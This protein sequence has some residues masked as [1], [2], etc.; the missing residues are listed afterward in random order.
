MTFKNINH[1]S[2]SV[3]LLSIT[4]TLNNY[5]NA[6]GENTM[7][8]STIR[9]P[10]EFEQQEA[11]WLQWPGRWE[12]DSEAAFAK[13]TNIIVQYEKLHILHNNNT[14]R[15]EARSAIK[16]AGGNPDHANITWH[17]IGNDSAWMRDNGPVYVVQDGEMRIQNWQFDAWGGAFGKNILTVLIML[18][19]PLLVST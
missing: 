13:M 12:K 3:F 18:C 10:A 15:K 1:L 17:E 6:T 8:T 19:Q 2:I 5:A 11:I 14:I 7:T 4:I 9:V 16:S